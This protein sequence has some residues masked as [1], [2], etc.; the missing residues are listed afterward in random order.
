MKTGA[1]ERISGREAEDRHLVGAK[2][3]RPAR[4]LD[5]HI[6][7]LRAAAQATIELLAR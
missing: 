2:E 6:L 1:S 7:M 5:I 4:F 3:E